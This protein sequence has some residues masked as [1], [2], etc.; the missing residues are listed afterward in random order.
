MFINKE[1]CF[2]S[3]TIVKTTPYSQIL[4]VDIGPCEI[5]FTSKKYQYPL[6]F[7]RVTDN[8][9]ADRLEV[10]DAYA[11]YH[12]RNGFESK[13]FIEDIKTVLNLPFPNFQKV[14]INKTE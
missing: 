14:V 10:C 1:V 3:D 11:R 7:I 4:K 12:L 6:S 13:D 8:Q 5:R 2:L 9:Y